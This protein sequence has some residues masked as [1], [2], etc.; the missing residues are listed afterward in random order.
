M[1]L[2]TFSEYRSRVLAEAILNEVQIQFNK[3]RDTQFGNVVILAGG[4]GSGKGFTLNNLIGIQGKVFDVDEL[5]T[6]AMKSKKIVDQVN[7][8]Y[9]INIAYGEFDLRQAE[10][11]GAL[12]AIIGDDEFEKKDGTK[13]RG[14]SLDDKKQDTFLHAIKK[15]LEQKR[16][17]PDRLPNI[18]FDVTLKDMKKFHEIHTALKGLGYPVHKRHLVWIINDVEVA[19]SQ[20]LSRSR[21]VPEHILVKTHRGANATMKEIIDMGAGLQKFLDGDIFFTFAKKDIDN[22]YISGQGRE[23]KDGIGVFKRKKVSPGYMKEAT[24]IQLKEV[25]KAPRSSNQV[26]ADLQRKIDEYTPDDNTQWSK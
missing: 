23:D 19:K 1:K 11:V 3:N 6:Q 20:N 13:V 14:M 15:G 18:I 10:N 24:Y 26:A 16:I 4:A 12:H 7:K 21:V 22:L 2:P 8:E 9:G 5:K 25:G 17:D